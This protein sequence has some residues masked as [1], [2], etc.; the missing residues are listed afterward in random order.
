MRITYTHTV[1]DIKR[2]YIYILYIPNLSTFIHVCAR[3]SIEEKSVELI[4]PS[5]TSIVFFSAAS[6]D[7]QICRAQ[8]LIYIFMC[9]YM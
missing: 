8:A 9:V 6:R 3:F 5:L 7:D 1:Y 2:I 4:S